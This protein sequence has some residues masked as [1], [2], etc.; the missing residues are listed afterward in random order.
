MKNLN[1][2]KLFLATIFVTTTALFAG[3]VDD[4]DDTEAPR[5]EI[6]PKTLVFNDE[7]FPVDGSQD[8]F[9]IS[10]NRKWTATV[11]DDKTWVTL[12]K[13]EGNGSDKVQVS[14]PEGITDEATV[15]IQISNKVGVLLTEKVTIRSGNVVPK[16]VIYNETFG[17]MDASSNPAVTNYVGWDTTGE[18]ATNVT[19][20]GEG[21]TIRN[22]GK[23]SAEASYEGSG[24]NVV[25]FSQTG[26]FQINKIALNAEQTTLKLTFGGNYSYKPEGATEWD[27]TFNTNQFNVAL[28]SNGTEWVPISYTKNDGDSKEPFWIFATADFTL[29]HGIN[30]IYIKFTASSV[31]NAFRLDD[32][33]L[34]TGNGGQEIDLGT[35]D[36]T[37][38]T[39]EASQINGTSATLGGSLVN[40]DIASTTEVGVE[41]IEYTGE[42]ASINWDNATKTAATEK[43]TPWKVMITGLTADKQYAVRA[44]ATTATGKIYGSI[45]TFI[46]TAPEPISIADLVTKIKATTTE[47]PIDKDYVIQ[48]IICGDPQSKNCSFG[49]L[50]LMTKG[51]TTAGN[52]VT[53]YNT[54]IASETYSLGDEIKVI[55]RKENTKMQVYNSS[56][57]V[58]GFDPAE[59][60]K[61]SSNNEVIPVETTVDQLLDFVCMPVTIKNV[62][63]EQAG[64]W[65]QEENKYVT[66]KFK[67]SGADLTVYINKGAEI[68][69]DKPFAA[70]TGSITGIAAAYKTD[71]QILPRNLDDVKDFEITGPTI[72]SVTPKSLSLPATGG[73]EELIV[74]VMNF[75]GKT[76]NAK[77]LSG[78][79]KAEVNGT[80]VT[81]TASANPNNTAES[82]TLQLS[83]DDGNTVEVPIT[84]AGKPSEGEQT[85]I[86]TSAQINENKSGDIALSSSYG[87]QS[88]TDPSTWYRWA[89]SGIEFGGA[90]IL[91]AS[92]SGDIKGTIQVQGDASAE[93][94]QGLITNNTSLGKI[95]SITLVLI[96]NGKNDPT[97]SV[98]GG[99]EANALTTLITSTGDVLNPTFDFSSGDYSHFTIKN[100][101]TGALY[102]SQ[103]TIV[104]ENN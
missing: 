2:L 53:V 31:G 48:G 8:Y 82:Q 64:T 71:A 21:T 18:G 61:I 29:K 59:I 94:K 45:I 24:P 47:T 12:S 3:C 86:M 91:L 63:I 74:E 89:H 60:E 28:S 4:N 32:V 58:S 84:V 57:Q 23:S 7:G 42:V 70:K 14:I 25:F 6:S 96:K 17:T 43:V 97:Y 72:I 52:A 27:N 13:M 39:T 80:K 38:S 36:P 1:F 37:V 15:M 19:Y 30:N 20:T 5:L 68:F 100:N 92:N 66:H 40:M 103:I 87:S 56:P 49:T 11:V 51:A 62:T 102:V 44:Y 90:R 98:Y 46:A 79:L 85:L 50:Y 73:S 88:V 104:Y 101:K 77:G 83:V 34:S 67:V 10:A 65:K 76:L 26:V 55:L 81:V 35:T 99:T 41:Y 9:E 33:T 78:I 69:K 93:A 16:V 75:E 54:D 95:K 22:T